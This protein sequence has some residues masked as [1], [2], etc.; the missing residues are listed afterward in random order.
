MK[1]FGIYKSKIE[2][3]LMES[4]SNG[5]FKNTMSEFKKF[6]LNNK[7]ISEMYYLYDRL[8]EKSGMNKDEAKDLIEE[9]IKSFHKIKVKPQKL[10][11]LENW[12]KKIETPNEY[13]HLD[14]IF[15]EDVLKLESRISSKKYIIESLT[16]KKETTKKEVI[17]IPLKSSLSVANKT[18][19][20]FIDTLNESEKKEFLQIAQLD[21][22]QLNESFDI[23]KE[24]VSSKLV[25]ILEKE[26]DEEIKQKLRETIL[27]VEEEMPDRL[28]YY[29]LKKFNET[30]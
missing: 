10:K 16:S 8:S 13:F 24:E 3:V 12:L 9:C 20:N 19:S 6:V 15:S 22:K 1:S 14:E 5:T 25:Y 29:K 18:L 26:S 2:K 11:L 23:L 27:K 4:F 17:N 21:T 30:I 28:N 7:E